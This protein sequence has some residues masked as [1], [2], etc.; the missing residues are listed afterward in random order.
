[1]AIDWAFITTLEGRDLTG[2]VPDAEGSVSGVTVAAGIALGQLSAAAIDAMAIPDGLK[3][4][5]KPY[6]GLKK[7]AA[8]EFLAAHPLTI[9][10]ADADALE[11]AV[12]A[13]I[14]KTPAAH[15]HAAAPGPCRRP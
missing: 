12:R 6:A 8:V 7:Q 3:A 9:T 13:P 14:E 2:D 11:P 5:L 10:A 1:M 15:Y 4:K